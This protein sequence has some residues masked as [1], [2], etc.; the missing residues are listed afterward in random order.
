[1]VALI[2]G[3]EEL[4]SD[5]VVLKNLSGSTQVRVDATSA[6][7]KIEQLLEAQS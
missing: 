2:I 6:V 4:A 1:L 3:E 7:A 5:C